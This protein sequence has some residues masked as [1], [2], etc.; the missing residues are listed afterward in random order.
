MST[1]AHN[2]D[3]AQVLFL[4]SVIK[5]HA[6]VAGDLIEL[7]AHRWAIHGSILVDGDVLM[8]AYDDAEQAQRALS[9]L[10]RP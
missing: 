10:E 8:A 1:R 2:A 5:S 4:E 7:D 6:A 9:E 3:P